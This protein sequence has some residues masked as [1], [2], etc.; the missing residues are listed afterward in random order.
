MKK[1][2]FLILLVNCL[3]AISEE[4][5]AQ[6]RQQAQ[7]IINQN[8]Q[9]QGESIYMNKDSTKN[10]FVNSSI[11][12]NPTEENPINQNYQNSFYQQNYDNQFLSQELSEEQITLLKAAAR[13]KDLK[14]LQQK[15]FSKKYSGYE[16]TIHFNYQANKTQKITT[17]MA[18]AT[19]LIFSTKIDS[20]VLGD[21]LG[22][23]VEELSNLDNALAIT[24]KLIGIDSS[25]TV[26]TNDKKIH[27]FYIYSTNYKS[28]KD[29]DLVVYI[30]DDNAKNQ[31]QAE[32]QKEEEKYLII[33]DG[34][35]ELKVKKDEI[36]DN[37]LQ[38]ALQRNKALLAEE[39]FNDKQYTYFKYD[40]E[41]MP[42]IP[43]VFV[44]IDGQDSPIQSRVIGNYLIAETTAKKFTIRLGDSYICVERLN[45]DDKRIK[46]E[47]AKQ[48]IDKLFEEIKPK[49]KVE[50]KKYKG[51]DNAKTNL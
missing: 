17:R 18:M 49:T 41:R 13:A 6:A 46:N 4:E 51:K 36:Y 23:K 32:K 38:K 1:I 11:R 28:S 50:I 24:P 29:P 16:N 8:N 22:F 3:F 9:N 2:F 44:V 34:I 40:K 19:T 20:F 39:I 25:L 7:E 35:A 48:E 15:F 37:Y 14:S 10:N 27:T 31:T 43:S 42:Q 30:D 47:R 33:K 12:I 45:P 5:L 26:F 21:E